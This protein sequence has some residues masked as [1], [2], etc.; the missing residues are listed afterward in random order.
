MGTRTYPCPSPTFCVL[1]RKTRYRYVPSQS[2]PLQRPTHKVP[3]M[4][5]RYEVIVTIEFI[6]GVHACTKVPLAY[7]GGIVAVLLEHRWQRI[8]ARLYQQWVIGNYTS[9]EPCSPAVTSC[10][11]SITCGRT[12]GG[13]SMGVGKPDAFL[14]QFVYVGSFNPI[15]TITGKIIPS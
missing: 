8:T 2:R 5:R 7:A 15:I 4:Y 10:Q 13:G 3:G 14:G 9:F 12:N 1:R 6:R 11:K